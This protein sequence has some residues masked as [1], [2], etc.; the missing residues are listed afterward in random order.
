ML[1]SISSIFKPQRTQI[2]FINKQVNYANRIV[3]C[4]IVIQ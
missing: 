3:F 1:D 4:Y 2:Q